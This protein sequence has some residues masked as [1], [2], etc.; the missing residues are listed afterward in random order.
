MNHQRHISGP[1]LASSGET[2]VT[3]ESLTMRIQS[4]SRYVVRKEKIGFV[5]GRFILDTVVST[6]ETME[7]ARD[8]S[9]QCLMLKTNFNEAYD[10][11]D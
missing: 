7:Q 1:I 2:V 9:R 6:Y 3:L 8:T 4:I 10:H 5:Q 11:V